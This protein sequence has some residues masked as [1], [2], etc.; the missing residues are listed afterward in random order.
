MWQHIEQTARTLFARANVREIRTPIFEATE[1]F[2]RGVGESTDIVNKEMYT[3]EKGDRLL[4]LRPENTAGV[5]RAYIQHG[6]DRQPKPVKL[7]YM[8]PM[9]R[10]ER[11]Q[12]GR[13]RQFHQIGLEVFGVDTPQ[14]DANVILLA[15]ELFETLGVPELGLEINNVGCFDCRDDFKE[16]LKALLEPHLAQLCEDCNKRFITNPLR[17][18]DCK[19]P[20]CQAIYSRPEISDF[21]DQDQTCSACQTRF[22]E[23]LEILTRCAIPF[24]RN[25]MLVRGLDYYTRTVF[26]ITSTNLGAQNAVCGG[27][28]YNGLV[29]TLGGLDTPAVGWALGV[30]RLASLISPV[31]ATS[32]QF[33]I[34][35]DDAPAA[36]TLAKS[37]RRAGYSVEADQSGKA[38]GKQLAQANKLNAQQ[39]ILLGETERAENKVSV[40]TFATGVQE[41][42]AQDA[43][44]QQLQAQQQSKPD[45]LQPC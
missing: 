40:K 12:A 24:K 4:T 2:E 6:L 41:T 11:P 3:F 23:L 14:A 34:V 5:V 20:A 39:V 18:L 32:L 15:M 21:L 26:E 35:S 10:Y 29:K 13:Q 9:F 31:S 45:V 16:R 7:F 1:L 42:F 36:L 30:E 8:G 37:I 38:I 25:K 22:S 28:R 19:N 44:L 33:Y 17:M 27:G 43:F